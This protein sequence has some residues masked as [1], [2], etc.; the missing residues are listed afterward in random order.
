MGDDVFDDSDELFLSSLELPYDEAEWRNVCDDFIDP[1]EKDVGRLMARFPQ[2]CRVEDDVACWLSDVTR[3]LAGLGDLGAGKH[4]SSGGGG[5][6]S[7][8]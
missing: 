1:L 7:N 4:S 6:R 8:W 5:A 2:D 3:V